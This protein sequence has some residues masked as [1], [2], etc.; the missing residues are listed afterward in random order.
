MTS[1]PQS[2][3]MDDVE[4]TIQSVPFPFELLRLLPLC[5]QVELLFSTMVQGK[6]RLNGYGVYIRYSLISY[7]EYVKS[8]KQWLI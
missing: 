2:C 8:V 6:V 5:Q 4:Q 3:G 7:I 1:E